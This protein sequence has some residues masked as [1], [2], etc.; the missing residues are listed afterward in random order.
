MSPS[1]VGAVTMHVLLG[2]QCRGWPPCPGPSA[3]CGPLSLFFHPSSSSSSSRP[4]CTSPSSCCRGWCC[5]SSVWNRNHCCV[6]GAHGAVPLSSDWQA[7]SCI[8][9]FQGAG[10][11][12]IM[13]VKWNQVRSDLL[14]TRG[15]S[16]IYH[17]YNNMM[18]HYTL[19]TNTFYMW[20][21][22]TNRGQWTSQMWSDKDLMESHEYQKR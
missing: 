12:L 3:S 10:E 19:Y 22:Q 9:G 11:P 16:E 7:S 1:V 21:T 6:T 20:A 2:E 8:P 15:E 14:Q 18:V 5:R 13:S 17:C 4:S